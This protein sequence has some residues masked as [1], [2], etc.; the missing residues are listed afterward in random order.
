[1]R[2]VLIYCL[3]IGL[4]SLASQALAKE[5][6]QCQEAGLEDLRKLEAQGLTQLV[7]FASWC[8]SCK[9]HMEAADPEQTVFVVAYD[10]P[11]AAQAALN[12]IRP[13]ARYCVI[14]QDQSIRRSFGVRSLPAE[15]ELR[16]PQ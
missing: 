2:H 10:S 11:K 3:L 12:R 14:D 6:T 5:L 4:S 13:E 8:L 16:L 9:E 15:R 1:M 7:F